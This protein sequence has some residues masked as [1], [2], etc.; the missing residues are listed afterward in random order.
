M[1]LPE[2]SAAWFSEWFMACSSFA[3]Y[4]VDLAVPRRRCQRSR[5]RSR[6]GAR[7][8]YSNQAAAG[9][10]DTAARWDDLADQLTDLV[11]AA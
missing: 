8:S 10:V 1:R 2:P 7:P 3:A 9:V 5:S 11:A 6:T 4:N